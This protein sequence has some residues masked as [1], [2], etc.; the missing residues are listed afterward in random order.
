MLAVC[1]EL[2]NGTLSIA[3]LSSS[4]LKPSLSGEGFAEDGMLESG[5]PRTESEAL[6]A[7]QVTMELRLV[8]VVSSIS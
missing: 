4:Y 3:S 1:W 7:R 6:L 2:E 8:E 5:N